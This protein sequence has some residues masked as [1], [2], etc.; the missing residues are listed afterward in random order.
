[1]ESAD[2]DEDEDSDG[3]SWGPGTPA[4]S[5]PSSGRLNPHKRGKSEGK[6][7]AKDAKRAHTVVERS[8]FTISSI[9]E[10][11]LLANKN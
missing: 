5:E 10:F 1:M 6:M 3:Y 7:R 4:T 8:K 2:G 11:E 9:H